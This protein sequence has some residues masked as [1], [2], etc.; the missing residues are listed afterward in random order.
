MFEGL[1][2][3]IVTPFAEGRLDE[4][5]LRRVVA[6]LLD[7]GVDGIVATGSTGEAATLSAPE[8]ERVWQIVLEE[9]RGK[10]FVLAGTGTNDTAETLARTRRAAELG[11]DG[12]L[13]VAPYYNKPQ[14]RGL[15][16]HFRR[17]ADASRVPLMLYNVPSRTAV[18]IPP[19]VV[20]ELAAHPNI[21]AVKEASGSWDQASEILRSSSITVL[22]GEDAGTLPLLALG[23]RGVVSVAGHVA[24]REIQR[25]L[26]LF[27]KGD[28]SGA[29]AIHL[30]LH[31]LIQALFVETNPAPVKA[32]LA[33]LGLIRDEVRPPLVPAAASTKALLDPILDGLGLLP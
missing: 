27:A 31:P 9:A 26:G 2:V 28:A 5:G 17:V 23:A 1:S 24:G 11:V 15:V 14:P 6:H 22:S 25:M 29:A 19:A 3:A 32:A 13:V 20:S 33:R 7:Q 21:A 16:E 12:C 4:D 30:R 10:A 8:R 18:N